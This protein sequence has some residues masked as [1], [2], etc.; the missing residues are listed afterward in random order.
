[1]QLIVEVDFREEIDVK[2]ELIDAVIYSFLLND[3]MNQHVDLMVYLLI[4]VFLSVKSFFVVE[5]VVEVLIQLAVSV[6]SN[7]VVL[8]VDSV[9]QQALSSMTMKM[10]LKLVLEQTAVEVVAA[11]AV[12]ILE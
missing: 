1:M 6:V 10:P 12:V 9:E 2:Q 5:D 7:V 3:E 11:A 8:F 4:D